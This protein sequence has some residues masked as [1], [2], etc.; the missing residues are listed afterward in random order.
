M[1]C[2][3]DVVGVIRGTLR[4]GSHVELLAHPPLRCAMPP[5]QATG[6]FRPL[7]NG[8]TAAASSSVC[9]KSVNDA[10][11]RPRL[12]QASR[13]TATPTRERGSSARSAIR[14]AHSCPARWPTHPSWA[15]PRHRPRRPHRPR[16]HCAVLLVYSCSRPAPKRSPQ[17]HPGRAPSHRHHA[18]P[19]TPPQFCT[20]TVAS[21]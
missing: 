20:A 16:A 6:T 15:R 1:R 12:N 17:Q 13:Q 19:P 9:K 7:P 5:R 21:H 14:D 8:I 4:T 18:A 11:S 10:G 2:R 3:P